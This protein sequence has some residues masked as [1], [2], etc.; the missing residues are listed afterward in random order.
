M[1]RNTFL[2]ATNTF[3]LAWVQF[4]LL[5]VRNFFA[6]FFTCLPEKIG[7]P[8]TNKACWKKINAHRLPI[9]IPLC[10]GWVCSTHLRSSLSLKRNVLLNPL[11]NC[12]VFQHTGLFVLLQSVRA[13]RFYNPRGPNKSAERMGKITE[14][15]RIG[16]TNQRNS[17]TQQIGGTN[18]RGRPNSAADLGGG[19][20]R[21]YVEIGTLL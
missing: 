16:K 17:E 21:R 4:P 20:C 13:R 6:F 8:C 19:G 9:C 1:P 12:N 10:A 7:S 14:T 5:T 11:C 15:Q 18:R 3:L 2:L